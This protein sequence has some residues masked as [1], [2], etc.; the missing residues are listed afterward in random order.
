MAG[1]SVHH[2]R[3][4][5]DVWRSTGWP[6]RDAIEIELLAAG[7]LE[8]VHDDQGR[9]TLRVSDA[10]VRVLAST[11]EHNRASRSPHEDLVARVALEMHRAGR[12]VWRGLSLR[13]P[14]DRGVGGGEHVR[15]NLGPATHPEPH[16]VVAIPDVFSVRQTTIEAY[17]EPVVHEVKVR[18]ADLLADVKRPDKRAA[19]LAL[20]GEC[21]YVLGQGIGGADDVPEDCGVIVATRDALVAQRPAPR[22]AGRLPFATWM[23]LAKATRCDF[24]DDVAQGRL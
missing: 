2:R 16:W 12:L 4:L 17:L 15:G 1:L 8:R 24:G 14:L 23:A 9:E 7:W 5:R 21:W 19:Y 10:G 11:L 20:A 3:R 22:R 18:R 6:C 13:A